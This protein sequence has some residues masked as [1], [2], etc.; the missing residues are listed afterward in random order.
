MDKKVSINVYRYI[1][2]CVA[3]YDTVLFKILGTKGNAGDPGN[4]GPRG[5]V[6]K[7]NIVVTGTILT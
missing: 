1:Y 7:L 3:K 4:R 6:G 2:V 5:L